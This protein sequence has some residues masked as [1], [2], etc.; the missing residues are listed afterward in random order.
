MKTDEDFYELANEVRMYE[1]DKHLEGA[2]L[3]FMKEEYEREL[4]NGLADE[5]REEVDKRTSRVR[6]CLYSIKNAITR[7]FIRLNTVLR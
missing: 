6:I 7:F 4:L 3:S 2:K 5:I 1:A